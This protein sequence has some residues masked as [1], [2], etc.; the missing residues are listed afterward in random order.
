MDNKN[1]DSNRR[2]DSDVGDYLSSILYGGK[3]PDNS[4]MDQAILTDYTTRITL[5]NFLLLTKLISHLKGDS[6]KEF[7]RRIL[8]DMT[9]SL[10]SRA[11]EDIKKHTDMCQTPLG[12]LVS[13]LTG[14]GEDLRLKTMKSINKAHKLLLEMIDDVDDEDLS[15]GTEQ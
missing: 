4:M 1:K 15:L 14:D 12:P 5:T 13:S 3:S 8:K 2:S 6:S 7:R 9:M 11:E 10:K